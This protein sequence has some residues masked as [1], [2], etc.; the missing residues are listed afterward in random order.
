MHETIFG[1]DPFEELTFA[2]NDIRTQCK[3]ELVDTLVKLRRGYVTTAANE[4]A[5]CD[6]LA[7]AACRLVPLLRAMLWLKEIDRPHTAEL[8]F[9]TS[10]VEFSIETHFITAAR[11]W[12]YARTFLRGESI[13][14][15]LESICI[16]IDRLTLITDELKI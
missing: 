15:V 2:K 5:I 9:S 8:V 6:M 7:S 10:A 4:R 12:R 14:T 16:A 1:D 13:S 11:R 3:R